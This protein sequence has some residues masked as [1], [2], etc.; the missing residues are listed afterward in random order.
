MSQLG[1][2]ADTSADDDCCGKGF[3]RAPKDSL[4]LQL[5]PALRAVVVAG[6]GADVTVRRADAIGSAHSS[7]FVEG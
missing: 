5:F 2:E 6:Q 4:H 3:R 1:S 7:P